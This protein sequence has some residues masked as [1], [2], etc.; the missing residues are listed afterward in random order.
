M[1]SL[2]GLL[3][4][5]ILPMAVRLVL[6]THAGAGDS[7]VWFSGMGECPQL[8][9]LLWDAPHPHHVSVR[10]TT[11]GTNTWTECRRKPVRSTTDG[12]EVQDNARR[13]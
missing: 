1:A 9:G 3:G 11:N 5:C 2:G 12:I 6:H 13:D 7:E 4:P 10:D 8:S